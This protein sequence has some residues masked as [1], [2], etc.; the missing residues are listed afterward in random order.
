MKILPVIRGLL[1]NAP[2]VT[3]KRAGGVFIND[4][5]GPNEPRPNVSMQLVSS[6]EEF[7]HQGPDGLVRDRVRIWS[8]GTTN[9]QAAELAA[10]ISATLN[11]WQGVRSGLDVQVIMKKMSISDYQENAQVHRQIDDYAVFWGLA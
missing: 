4:V 3:A 10:A 7:T 9:Q 11:G 8:R 1:I 6:L 5:P 2:A